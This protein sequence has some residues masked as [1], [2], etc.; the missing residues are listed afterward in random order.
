[1]NEKPVKYA[2]HIRGKSSAFSETPFKMDVS[3]TTSFPAFRVGDYIG[4]KPFDFQ[5]EHSDRLVVVDV[6]WDFLGDQG[7]E[8][9]HQYVTVR[10]ESMN[11]ATE[12]NLRNQARGS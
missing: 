1:M 3:S 5:Y 11:E 8:V 12:R 2:L 4:A 7:S 6:L 9:I 10:D